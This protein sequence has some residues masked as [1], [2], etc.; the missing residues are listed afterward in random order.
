MGSA[1]NAGCFVTGASGFL[2]RQV[3][4]GLRQASPALRVRC[5]VRD[6]SA[7]P[8][9]GNVELIQGDLRD[10][11]ALERGMQGCEAVVHLAGATHEQDPS[12]YTQVNEEG[13]RRVVGAAKRAGIR[14]FV[15]ASSR[16]IDGPCGAYGASKRRAE[17]LLIDSRLPYIILRFAEVYGV[18]ATGGLATL[19]HLVRTWP[20][21]PVVHGVELAPVEIHDAVQ[22]VLASLVTDGVEGKT[23][24]I[25]GPRSYALEECAR[26]IA[27]ALDVRRLYLPVPAATLRCF[28]RVARW[29]GGGRIVTDQVERLLCEKGADITQAV[30]ELG[31]RPRP[32]C[33]G[34]RPWC[35][36]F[37][38]R[39]S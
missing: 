27:D 8:L 3:V 30:K 9:D 38:G 10:E 20:V 29:T 26:L 25:A 34:V 14:R 15:F 39:R 37:G 11:R 22:A 6:R 28:G 2:G 23:Y 4:V 12:V 32:F 7:M 33:D 5:L 31:F 18:G 36:T 17:R 21:V 1:R 16:A 13:T 35:Q 24:T 19:V